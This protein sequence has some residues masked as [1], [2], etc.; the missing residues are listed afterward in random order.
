MA[1]LLTC[2]RDIYCGFIVYPHVHTCDSSL[3]LGVQQTQC[4]DVVGFPFSSKHL[5]TSKS[6]PHLLTCDSSL[7]STLL[8]PSASKRL[9]TTSTSFFLVAMLF[10]WLPRLPVAM[11]LWS[12]MSSILVFSLLQ[13]L[14]LQLSS[15]EQQ[16]ERISQ[17]L[18]FLNH[19]RH[20]LGS[21]GTPVC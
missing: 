4:W 14:S 12:Y 13:S 6:H 3:L 18:Q 8:L 10:L 19:V 9:N 16:Q 17:C 15:E 1:W 11:Y 21:M 5:L 20:I 2:G 7:L